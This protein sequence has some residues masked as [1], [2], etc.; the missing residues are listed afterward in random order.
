MFVENVGWLFFHSMQKEML[1]IYQTVSEVKCF[2]SKYTHTHTR[3]P[4]QARKSKNTACTKNCTRISNE[5]WELRGIEKERG[6]RISFLSEHA[7]FSF[8]YIYQ[9]WL[10]QMRVHYS[11]SFNFIAIHVQFH[12]FAELFVFISFPKSKTRIKTKE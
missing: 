8:L 2:Q 12:S 4:T 5:M 10:S 9:L 1:V 6:H 3:S 11:R 7:R